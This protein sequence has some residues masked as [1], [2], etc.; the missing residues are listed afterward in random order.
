MTFSLLLSRAQGSRLQPPAESWHIEFERTMLL[1][2]GITLELI[3]RKHGFQ[4]VLFEQTVGESFLTLLE[5]KSSI[6]MYDVAHL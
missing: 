5:G 6:L 4:D 2:A 1:T 3:A